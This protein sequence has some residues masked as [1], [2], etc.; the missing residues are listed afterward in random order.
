LRLNPDGTIIDVL[1]EKPAA[2]AGIGP[3]MKV[4]AINDRKYSS[5][6]LREEIRGAKNTGSLALLVAN[7]KSFSTYTLNYRDGEKYPVLEPNGQPRFLDEILKPH[8]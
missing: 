1:P 7:G 5:D 3:G 2:K 6:V 4:V 8:L